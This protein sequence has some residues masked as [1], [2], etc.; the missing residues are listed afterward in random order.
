MKKILIMLSLV[1]TISSA[2]T[3]IMNVFDNDDN[4]IT[5]EGLYSTGQKTMGAMIRLESLV[6]GEILFKQRFPQESEL[7]ISI[8]SEP[9]QVVLD[10]G[11]GHVIVEKGIAPKE[12]FSKG[13]INKMNESEINTLSIA[14]NSNREWGNT[15]IF[16]FTLCLIL[17]SLCIYFSNENTKKI[18]KLIEDKKAT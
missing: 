10:G 7:T 8:P 11:P 3:L 15:T 12:G 6:S 17:L 2:H 5:V 1:Y 13:I 9:Y 18:Y 14:Q 4:T 16:L